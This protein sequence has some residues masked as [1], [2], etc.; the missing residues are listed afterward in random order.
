MFCKY[1]IRVYWS[2]HQIIAK[3]KAVRRKRYTLHWTASGIALSKVDVLFRGDDSIYQHP[4][5]DF[6]CYLYKL[7]QSQHRRIASHSF[8]TDDH[9]QQQPWSQNGHSNRLQIHFR[10]VEWKNEHTT[11]DFINCRSD[12]ELNS[13]HTQDLDTEVGV[14]HLNPPFTLSRRI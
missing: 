3:E 7:L 6:I 8:W 10:Y 12:N 5:E 1:K 2:L 14:E 13:R 11:I 9:P 4:L